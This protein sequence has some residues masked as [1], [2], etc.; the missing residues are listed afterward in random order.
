[1]TD[2]SADHDRVPAR[3]WSVSQSHAMNECPRAW[4]FRYV[5]KAAP[6]QPR[7]VK[8]VVGSAIHAGLEAAYLAAK[9]NAAWAGSRR[10]VDTYAMAALTAFSAYWDANG[11][12]IREYE[13]HDAE[14]LLLELLDVLVTPR[15]WEI[16][17]VEEQFTLRTFPQT[18]T[19][20]ATVTGVMDLVFNTSYADVKSIHIRDWKLGTVPTDPKE[21]ENN[22]QLCTYAA[23]A[24]HRWP[25][26]Q[27][28]TVGLYSIRE[29]REVITEL[30]SDSINHAVNQL[31]Y[32]AETGRL[33][34]AR[35]WVEPLPGEHCGGCRF[36]S[37]CPTM[38]KNRPPL[39]PGVDLVAERA[40]IAE[41][42][43]S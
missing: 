4:W 25:W 39:V 27:Q 28:I 19:P 5:A 1:M 11:A 33:R 40:M 18:N 12:R 15:P 21:L 23:A 14:R 22:Q 3:S 13:R 29:R 36:R 37:Y 8:Q 41:K 9:A 26:V 31:S 17:G 24:T 38:V 30:H 32:D 35:R 10:M 2:V 34:A 43:T 6:A 20:P 7:P 16:L 42:L